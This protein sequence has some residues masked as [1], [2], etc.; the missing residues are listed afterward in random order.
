MD[1]VVVGAGLAGLAAARQL[2]RSGYEVEVL[3]ADDRLGGRVL[4]APLPG[5]G[6]VELGA[7]WVGADHAAVRRLAQELGVGLAEVD[8]GGEHV[9]VSGGRARR[10]TGHLPPVGNAARAALAEVARLLPADA[11]TADAMTADAMTADPS[12]AAHLENTTAY[13]WLSQHVPDEDARW[14]LSQ[15]LRVELCAEP[16]QLGAAELVGLAGDMDLTTFLRAD[17]SHRLVGGPYRLARGLAAGLDPQP[18]LNCPVSA[19]DRTPGGVRV[20]TPDGSRSAAAVVIATP[21]AMTA[22]I[23]FTP[24]LPGSTDQLLQRR[25]MGAVIKTAAVYPTPFWRAA[26]LSGYATLRGSDLSVVVD[27]SPPGGTAGVL[28]GFFVADTARRLS[29]AT[30]AVRRQTLLAQLVGIFG[31]AAAQPV[32][33]HE[34][35]WLARPFIRGGYG[36]YHPPG[37]DPGSEPDADRLLHD[38]RVALATA[39]LGVPHAGYMD[40][41]LCSG[42]AAAASVAR[43]LAG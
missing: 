4:D 5:G 16:G 35:D 42:L 37:E 33:L 39:D 15:K 22:R 30:P 12:R 25:P 3:E 29:A 11:L 17:E 7:Q 40:G 23:R 36:A 8:G 41:A 21:L 14:V 9:Y 13:G 32:A 10:Y 2:V 19:V 6:A 43:L 18:R 20:H 34:Q 31:P 1:V 26:G 24:P 28:T 27:S 38:H